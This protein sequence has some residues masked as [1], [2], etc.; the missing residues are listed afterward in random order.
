MTWRSGSSVSGSSRRWLR[1]V[2]PFEGLRAVLSFVE[3][4]LKPDTTDTA[5]AD[6]RAHTKTAAARMPAAVDQSPIS[7]LQSITQLPNYPITK[8]VYAYAAP[9]MIFLIRMCGE[10]CEMLLVWVGWPFASPPVPNICHVSWLPI[11]SRFAQKSVVI[12]L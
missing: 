4:R 9:T 6:G 8:S 12:A 2:R 1:R 5:E 11:A 10:P 7:N 3:G